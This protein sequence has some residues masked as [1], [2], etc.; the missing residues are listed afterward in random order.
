MENAFWLGDWTGI[1]SHKRNFITTV[2]ES[3]LKN[4]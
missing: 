3:F 2:A 1:D 4:Y